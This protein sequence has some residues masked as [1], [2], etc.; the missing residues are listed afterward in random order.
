MVID[1]P[2]LSNCSKIAAGIWNPV[3]FKRLTKSWMADDV[4][5]VMLKFYK[6][7]QDLS[8]EIFL[9]D[10]NI[11]KLFSEQQEIELWRK[12]STGELNTYLDKTIYQTHPSLN[13]KIN[14]LGFSKVL[15]CGNLDV[16]AFL[17]YSR[18]YLKA[19]NSFL[20]ERFDHDSLSVLETISYK[21]LVASNIIFAEGHLIKNN[22]F[23]SY[24]PT[25]P[26]KGEIISFA[27][28]DLGT[29]NEIINKNG[30]LMRIKIDEYKMGATYS[31]DDQTD[32]PTKEG[33]K[34]LETKL[35]KMIDVPYAITQHQAGVR[36]SVIDR[37][38]IL[39]IHPTYKNIFVFNGLGTKGVMLAP[40]FAEHMAQ[41]LQKK[42]KLIPEVDVARFNKFFVN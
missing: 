17:N 28:N 4:L 20:E 15:S 26:A 36:P 39:G 11:V 25:K 42:I 38:P 31:W 34:Q 22:P 9:T 24:I 30:F 37:R 8:S 12:K 29:G 18:N 1:K 10:R 23:F 40:Y 33:L 32:I 6:K 19:Q 7:Y 3:V 2:E 5:P 21:T 13:L 41:Y 27:T 35:K 16:N 14:E